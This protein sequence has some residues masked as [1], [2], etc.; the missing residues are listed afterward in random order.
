MRRKQVLKLLSISMAGIL[1]LA[2][3]DITGRI[4]YASELT[5]QNEAAKEEEVVEGEESL[6]SSFGKE[7]INGEQ[8]E[9]LEEETQEEASIEENSIEEETTEEETIEEITEEA[10]ALDCKVDSVELHQFYNQEL[11]FDSTNSWDD[12]GENH[13]GLS[14]SQPLNSGTI[15]SFDMY[16]PSENADFTG[17]LKVQGVARLGSG[18]SWTQN[19][20]IPEFSAKDFTEEVEVDGVNYKKAKV[21]FTFGEEITTDY[22]AEFTVKL[23]GWMCDYEGAVYYADV[24]LKDG[25]FEPVEVETNA[26]KQWDFSQG[27]EGWYY[28]GTWDNQGNNSILWSEEYQALAMNVDY[29]KDV[30]STWSEIKSS[31]WNDD[32]YLEGANKITF[33]FIFDSANMQKGSFKIKLFSNSGI[34]TYADVKLDDIENYDGSLKVAH[35]AMS[36]D[37]TDIEKGIT[38]G[39]IG[40]ETDY[41]GEIYLD[42]VTILKEGKAV[43]GDIYVD[44]SEEV[45]GQEMQLSVENGM[46]VTGAGNSSI[47]TEI[48]LVDAEATESVKQVYA[49]L[50]A[51]GNT[52]SVIFGQQNNTSHKAGD[53]NL[54]C[55]D[56]MDVVNSYTGII[57]IDALSMTGNE[58]SA[59]RYLNEMEDLDPA[60]T[61]VVARIE[62]A[63]TQE[64]KNVI[65]AAALTNFNIRSGAIATLSLHMPNF[66]K[67]SKCETTEGAPSYTGYN[68]SGYTPNVLSGDVMNQILPG[69]VY[70]E[71]F[72]AYL[73]M[74]ADYAHMVDGA[75]LFRP[76]HE[77]TGSWFW[78]GA[79]F[80]DEQTYKSVYKY[81]VE[82]LRDEK[83]VHNFLYVYGPGSEAANV[84]EYAKRYPGDG[85]VDMVGFDMYHSNPTENDSFI[86]NFKGMLSIADTF[87]KEHGKLVAVTETGVANDVADGDNQTAML[88]EGNARLDW[89]Q[90][91]L[92]AVKESNASYYLVWANF[93]E[94]DGFYT[95]YVKEVK[96]DGTKHGHEMQDN[97][98][99]FFN[100]N[101]S[102]F[103][104]NQKQAL[105]QMQSVSVQ[106]TP[107][108]TQTGYIV[109]PISGSRILEENELHA[110]VSGVSAEDKV[111]FVCKG[112]DTRSLDA[113]YTDGYVT[114]ILTS[115]DLQAMGEKVGEICL[116]INGEIVD[117][118]RVSFNIPEAEEDPY[119]IDGFENYYGVDTMLTKS[120]TTNK[121]T[122][123]NIELSLSKDYS[124]EGEYVMK[125][126]Y[127]ETA[128]GWAGATIAKEVSWDDCDALQFW[129]IPDG[130]LQ[131]TV[132]QITANGNVY[133]YYVNTNDDYR[134]AG[135]SPILVT[136]PFE[137]FVARDIAGNPAGGLADD[138]GNITSVGLWVNAIAG[139]EAVNQD[140]MVSGTLYYDNITAV[141]SGIKEVMIKT[142]ESNPSKPIVPSEP[143][144][145]EAS[146]TDEQEEE[147]TTTAQ[148]QQETLTVQPSFT[149]V[150]G[151]KV[152]GWESVISAAYQKAQ[153]EGEQIP[154]ADNAGY[155][156]DRLKV[157]LNITGVT[158]LVI[159]KTA[160]A[161][162]IE[163]GADYNFYYQNIAITIS[164]KELKDWSGIIDLH[165]YLQQNKNFGEGFDALYIGKRNGKAMPENTVINALLSEE[166]A[167]HF[168]YIFAKNKE[169]GYELM[170][171]VNIGELG[172]ITVPGGAYEE[173]MILY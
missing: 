71:A 134:Q 166:K 106:A 52:D 80:C 33:D 35:F 163:S 171:A 137:K 84:E 102:V 144:V 97:F 131:K 27:I 47:S 114:A 54:S 75:I 169:T 6:D 22:L 173:Y 10:V 162:M 123:S 167:N 113:E 78:W 121:A 40:C 62:H 25:D 58:Y 17:V 15:V 154:L 159:P 130:N 158:E 105:E 118:I 13:M 57:G 23:A 104:V 79:A 138:K 103:A 50:Q 65:A 70:N 125:F 72:R 76:F 141:A 29:A 133:E 11:T 43:E 129:T 69:G 153:L 148:T 56:T 45:T 99:R 116:E 60:Y 122:G 136:I 128:D 96:E 16:I 66:S 156:A 98:I 117:S 12:K 143:S 19:A 30:S 26:L 127:K 38:L 101:E 37:E 53:K 157:N 92:D 145:S 152:K 151:E 28:D 110:K 146:S 93:S 140:G 90:E 55:S 2:S 164:H 49:Y 1:T 111:T 74:V 14:T 3:C 172:T 142:L 51:V 34:D 32:L 59:D 7:S 119:E 77:N 132:I 147:N 149:T 150:D 39:V 8:E 87:A 44:A 94:T 67:V 82:Y 42:N 165:V 68:F 18:W 135:T 120:W 112:V 160:V 36:F 5:V 63:A 155:E 115:Q 61:E 81:T 88:K 41:Q 139:S 46:L 107:A 124:Y 168:A 100:R 9:V 108:A 170:S 21:S 86:T 85:Y 31:F 83:N 73:D 109:A 20:T 95:P 4:A 89:H 48:T 161:K 91:I 24:N 64:E 126:F